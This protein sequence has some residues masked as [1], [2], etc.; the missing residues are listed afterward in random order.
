[1]MKRI[2]VS[3]GLTLAALSAYS[4]NAGDPAK[5]VLVTPVLTTSVTS[6]GQAIVL[7]SKDSTVIVSTYEI[8]KGA[9]LPEHKHP[10]PRYAY[11]LAG[12]I[13]VTNTDA[14]KSETYKAGDFIIEAIGQWH[15]AE[16]VGDGPVKLLV[17][18]QVAGAGG[19][20]ILQQ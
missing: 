5:N 9:T 16:N 12:E 13:R 14:G 7:P 10:Y 4:A 19:N 1:M 17:I 11:V 8:A 15:H 2:L 20:V 18:D 3:V 6:S